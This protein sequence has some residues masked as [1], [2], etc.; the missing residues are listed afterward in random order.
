MDTQQ[1]TLPSSHAKPVAQPA[2]QSAACA[3]S[4]AKCAAR[5]ASTSPHVVTTAIELG[6]VYI[7]NISETNVADEPELP[8]LLQVS[9]PRHY[10]DTAGNANPD[11][12]GK[13]ELRIGEHAYLVDV[14]DLLTAVLCARDLEAC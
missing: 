2:P 12:K 1:S 6:L 11:Y 14:D 13:V 5:R 3:A 9:S 10:F 4:I 7:G 8:R